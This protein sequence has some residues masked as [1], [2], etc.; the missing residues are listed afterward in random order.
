M[1]VLVNCR[2]TFLKK[3]A[4]STVEILFAN[5]EGSFQRTINWFL[6]EISTMRG[7]RITPGL[8]EDIKV[9]YYNSKVALKEVASISLIDSRTLSV[10]PWDKSSIPSIEKALYDSDAGGSVKSE[11]N[12]ILFSLPSF[13]G[14]D[15]EK[16]IKVL[17]QKMEKAR[18]SL[19]QTREEAWSKIQEMERKSEISEDEKYRKKE[20]LQEKIKK[21]EDKVEELGKKKEKEMIL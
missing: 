1:V 12:R 13:T 2:I 4:S 16:I 7:S 5:M 11:K 14:E 3:M 21:F 8:I 19:R 15:R 6:R 18:I 9:D 20:E 17:K 10:D